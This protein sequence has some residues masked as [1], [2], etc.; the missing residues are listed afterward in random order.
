MELLQLH[1]PDRRT[2]SLK[3]MGDYLSIIDAYHQT[4]RATVRR[5]A[6]VAPPT[7]D[8]AP[9]I[10]RHQ[11]GGPWVRRSRL[12]TRNTDQVLSV[13]KSVKDTDGRISAKTAGGGR[14][15]QQLPA[16]RIVL[17]L[18]ADRLTSLL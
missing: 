1:R 11:A 3:T 13:A 6:C 17:V 9:V 2:L 7:K 12:V 5:H 14:P 18:V 10:E 15:G 8:R 16:E 4:G